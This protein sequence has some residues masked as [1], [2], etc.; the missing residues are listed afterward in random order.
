MTSSEREHMRRQTDDVTSIH[1]LFPWLCWI[2]MALLVTACGRKT[3][4][5]IAG[6]DEHRIVVAVIYSAPPALFRDAG[7]HVN[8][9]MYDIEVELSRRLQMP[10]VYQPT[11]FENIITGIQSG[12]FDIGNGVDATPTRQEVVDIVPLYQGSYSFLI[13]ADQGRRIGGRMADLCGL[14]VGTVAGGSDG[15][16]L[17]AQAKLCQDAGKPPIQLLLFDSQPNALLALRS[18]KVDAM[19]AFSWYP[20]LPGTQLSGPTFSRVQTG[21][22]LRKGSSLA[23]R[24]VTAMNELIADGTY[25]KILARYDVPSVA[26]SSA[27]LNPA[28]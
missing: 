7:G 13:L 8:G 4:P 3:A 18:H 5:S 11:S 26:L 24:L 27:S 17:T 19:T 6:G 25:A 16:T 10:F 2:L 12:K 23:P 20:A 21:V 15:P 22:A 14:T 9:F 28:R 1:A